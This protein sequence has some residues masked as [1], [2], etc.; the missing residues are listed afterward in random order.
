[1]GVENEHGLC[2]A[3]EDY[4]Y[5][6]NISSYQGHGNLVTALKTSGCADITSPAFNFIRMKAMDTNSFDP[7]KDKGSKKTWTHNF[8]KYN[9]NQF[10]EW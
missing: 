10:A 2:E 7:K 5:T 4:L 9:W 8:K 6:P 3:N 1:M